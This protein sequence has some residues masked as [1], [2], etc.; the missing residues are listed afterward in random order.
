MDKPRDDLAYRKINRLAAI[1]LA[2]T[3]MVIL[4]VAIVAI[5]QN[6][7]ARQLLHRVERLE[8]RVERLESAAHRLP[9]SADDSLPTAPSVPAGKATRDHAAQ[10]APARPDAV[11]IDDHL[12]EMAARVRAGM[13]DAD[14][15]DGSALLRSVPAEAESSAPAPAACLAAAEIAMALDDAPTCIEWAR[16][17]RSGGLADPRVASLLAAAYE[18]TGDLA[19][20]VGEARLAAA[21]S[22][23]PKP[24]AQGDPSA[25][26][27]AP[28]ETRLRLGR[29]E[30]RL[31]HV[32][33][34]RAALTPLIDEPAVRMEAMDLLAG[35]LVQQKEAD[36]ALEMLEA[37][38]IEAPGDVMILRRLAMVRLEI[39]SFAGC[40]EAARA[41]I[42]AGADDREI[43]LVLGRCL[44]EVGDLAGA[45]GT[46]GALT[47]RNPD[48]VGAWLQLGAVRLAALDPS[49][50]ATAFEEALRIEPAS[51]DS[52]YRLGVAQA[53]ADQC[54]AA[55]GSFDTCIDF[56]P[57]F[58]HAHF[59]RAVCLA[60]MGDEAA[61]EQSLIRALA[62]DG[63]LMPRAEQVPVLAALLAAMPDGDAGGGV[64]GVGEADSD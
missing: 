1:Q 13:T 38:A 2:T 47:V 12:I 59:A 37:A 26:A 62:L 19:A 60:R 57:G 14:R 48:D 30:W 31:G 54:A 18:Q 51:A 45:A 39:G 61:A 58:A 32:A 46:L 55:T 43:G 28:P 52:W 29:L 33:E 41:A 16:R 27:V 42:G 11:R 44:L 49:G 21:G 40:V 34:A 23:G 4:V 17:A 5:L 35:V 64:S 9:E 10:D 36:L 15:R 8:A 56:D 3:S 22:P 7:H 6:G 25:R 50:A 20:A 53:N 63:A 24:A